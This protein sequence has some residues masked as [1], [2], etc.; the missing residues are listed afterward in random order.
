[1][2]K[3]FF[4]NFSLCT[5]VLHAIVVF[6]LLSVGIAPVA[7]AQNHPAQNT[8]ATNKPVPMIGKPAPDFK[9]AAIREENSG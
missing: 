3:S 2:S 8:M 5:L 1:M 6:L 7:H 9:G 4:S